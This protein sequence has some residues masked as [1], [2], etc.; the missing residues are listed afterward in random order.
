[1]LLPLLAARLTVP[2]KCRRALFRIERFGPYIIASNAAKFEE[3]NSAIVSISTPDFLSVVF[4]PKIGQYESP[5]N[6]GL[7]NH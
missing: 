4:A 7:Q 3:V 2:T 6:T 1:M 5:P